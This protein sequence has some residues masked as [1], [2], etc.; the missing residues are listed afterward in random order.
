MQLIG[1]NIRDERPERFVEKVR[2]HLLKHG[3]S[4]LKTDSGPTYFTSFGFQRVKAEHEMAAV[5]SRHQSN[6][7]QQWGKTHLSRCLR[8]L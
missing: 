5:S 3:G 2:Y 6:S 7:D 4:E 8:S 1:V